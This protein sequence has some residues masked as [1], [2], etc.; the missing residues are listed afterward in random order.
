MGKGTGAG[1]GKGSGESSDSCLTLSWKTI[2]WRILFIPFLALDGIG[3][4]GGFRIAY[5]IKTNN[6]GCV[7]KEF[8]LY[9]A[10]W[11]PVQDSSASLVPSHMHNPSRRVDFAEESLSTVENK[12]T[13]R[14]KRQYDDDDYD[15][16][17]DDDATASIQD[18]LTDLNPYQTTTIYPY[19]G[20]NYQ[21]NNYQGNNNQGNN[22]QGDSY[23]VKQDD[24]CDEG[25]GSFD[26]DDDERQAEYEA[27]TYDCYLCINE[28][29][30]PPNPGLASAALGF[31]VIMCLLLFIGFALALKTLCFDCECGDEFDE[32]MGWWEPTKTCLWTIPMVVISSILVSK[33]GLFLEADDF[34]HPDLYYEADERMY[35]WAFVGS[36]GKLALLS[37]VFVVYQCCCTEEEHDEATFEE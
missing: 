8:G 7:G 11:N 13:N 10:N 1:K 23:P 12:R 36:V 25:R 30:P 9:D 16:Y 28:L 37:V 3:V 15:G 5:S 17:D 29:N 35:F 21:G 22:N 4:M 31:S 26:S 2:V 32:Y 27:G 33:Y 18:L 34:L 24:Q 19:Q 20:N 6:P 14:N